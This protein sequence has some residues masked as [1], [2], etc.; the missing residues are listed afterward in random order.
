MEALFPVLHHIY[1]RATYLFIYVYFEVQTVAKWKL[2]RKLKLYLEHLD[3]PSS[4]FSI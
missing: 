4:Y 3:T 2:K 1:A